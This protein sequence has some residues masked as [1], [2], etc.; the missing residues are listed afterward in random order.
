ME[1]IYR[2][3]KNTYGGCINHGICNRCCG[4]RGGNVYVTPCVVNDKKSYKFLDNTGYCDSIKKSQ[5]RVLS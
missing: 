4:S 3:K 5:L 2:L 1:K